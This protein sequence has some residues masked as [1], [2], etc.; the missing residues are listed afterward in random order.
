MVLFG[1]IASLDVVWNMAD[2][3]MALMAIINLIAITALGKF[4]YRTL[5][6]YTK[7]KKK[8]IKDPVF[9]ASSIE[10]LKNTTEWE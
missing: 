1:S 4:A 9:K 10:G 7:Q 3:F 8:G 5:D 6:D 2:V